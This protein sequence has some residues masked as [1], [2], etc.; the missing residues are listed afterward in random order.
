MPKIEP[1]NPYLTPKDMR[2]WAQQ[3]I[4]DAAKGLELRIRE[5]TGFVG[6]YSAGEISPE[7][8]D[9]LH[10]RYY[11][12]WGESLPG[13]SVSENVTDEQL[14][15]GIDKAAEAINGPFMTPAQARAGHAE[16]LKSG[17]GSRSRETP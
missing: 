12:R 4:Q 8:A 15:A 17:R 2:Q 7:K 16:R 5:L 10:S 14:L 13:H 11:H 1:E 3:E 9:E 6:A